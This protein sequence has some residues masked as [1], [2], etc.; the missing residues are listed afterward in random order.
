MRM[1]VSS[2]RHAQSL[3]LA[4]NAELRRI[5]V[6]PFQYPVFFTVPRSQ[7]TGLG[8]GGGIRGQD[9][10]ESFSTA[11]L[12]AERDKRR[13]EL[14]GKGRDRGRTGRVCRT[15]ARRLAQRS[16]EPCLQGLDALG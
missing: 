13:I 3:K 2:L 9:R 14:C 15:Y 7:H 6:Q 12:N 11:K 8:D 5:T 16:G 4:I 10:E 1:L